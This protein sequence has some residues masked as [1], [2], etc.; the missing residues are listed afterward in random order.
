MWAFC[1]VHEILTPQ[2]IEQRLRGFMPQ[3]ER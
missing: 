1:S 2:Q 3:A